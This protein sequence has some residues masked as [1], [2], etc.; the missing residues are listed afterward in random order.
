MIVI[1]IINSLSQI[2]KC[3]CEP[4]RG[5]AG[6]IMFWLLCSG[7]PREWEGRFTLHDPWYGVRNCMA[8]HTAVQAQLN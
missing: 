2:L 6:T 3:S 1:L 8:G 7:N 5:L 4:Q